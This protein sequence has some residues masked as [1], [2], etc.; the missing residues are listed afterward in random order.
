V[1]ALEKLAAH[2]LGYCFHHSNGRELA[3]A[4]R[5]RVRVREE[6][7]EEAPA[8]KRQ[9]TL[10]ESRARECK[11]CKHYYINPCTEKTKDDC[12]NWKHRHSK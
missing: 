8:P 3:M 12:S 6:E 5:V 10:A 2:D 1:V 9:P 7:P 11:F 4:K